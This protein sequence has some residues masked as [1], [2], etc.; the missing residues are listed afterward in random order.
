MVI[1]VIIDD[2]RQQQ[3]SRANDRVRVKFHGNYSSLTARILSVVLVDE[4]FECELSSMLSIDD[5]D[6]LHPLL[7]CC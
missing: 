1:A 3:R 6:E 7:R 5:D 4:S 2:E